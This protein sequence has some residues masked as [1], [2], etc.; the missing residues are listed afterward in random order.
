[1]LGHD[2]GIAVQGAP[3]PPAPEEPVAVALA[4]LPIA[5]TDPRL[6]HKTSDRAFYDDARV[7]AGTFELLFRN[8]RGE[9]TEGSFTNLFVPRGGKLLTAPLAAGLLPGVLRAEL[10]ERGAAV[11]ATL[12]QA[13]LDGEFFIGNSLRG[14]IRARLRQ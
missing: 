10:I 1:M 12:T 3:L 5:A 6:F 2:G 7:R 14:L 9:L 13:D 4:D 11:E 8:A